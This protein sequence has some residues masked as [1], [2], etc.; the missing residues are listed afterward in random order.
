MFIPLRTIFLASF[1]LVAAASTAA[2]QTAK[3]LSDIYSDIYRAGNI[4]ENELCSKYGQL[5]D[6]L[7]DINIIPD[8][9]SDMSIDRKLDVLLYLMC[10]G[11]S[12][13]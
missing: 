11:R 2:G 13:F 12:L 8:P 4:Y 9:N 7:P 5:F 10:K 1:V 6:S 3:E